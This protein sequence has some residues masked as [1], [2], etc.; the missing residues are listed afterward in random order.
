MIPRQ[1]KKK[2]LVVCVSAHHSVL[3]L[4]HFLLSPIMSVNCFTSALNFFFS[5]F[6]F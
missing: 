1:K 6:L 4:S 2:G 3:S 5:I